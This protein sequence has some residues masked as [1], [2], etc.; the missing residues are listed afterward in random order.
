MEEQKNHPERKPDTQLLKKQAISK[1]TAVCVIVLMCSI[2]MLYLIVDKPTQAELKVLEYARENG[3]S[4]LQY[5]E[6]LI[7]LL[8][9]NPETEQFVLNYPFREEDPEIHFSAMDLVDGIPP[10]MQW[11][12][13]WGYMEYGDSMVGINGCGPMCLAMVGYYLTGDATFHPDRIV[14]FADE[15]GFYIHGSGTKRTLISVGGRALGLDV[16]EL[17]VVESKIADYLQSDTPLIAVVSSGAF[18]DGDHFIVLKEYRDG[19]LK[20][21]DPS[22]YANSKEWDFEEIAEW[23]EEVWIIQTGE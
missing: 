10:F 22:S 2:L 16:K 15:N 4:A 11:D 21:I 1:L 19:K 17:A 5:P 14:K 18:G 20:I 13:R 9:E 23:M 3:I 12:E 6:E 7:A 8:E